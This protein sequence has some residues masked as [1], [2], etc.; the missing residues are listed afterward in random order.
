[1]RKEIDPKWYQIHEK[2]VSDTVFGRF[3]HP[4]GA[5]IPQKRHPEQNLMKNDQ[6]LGAPWAPKL[7]RKICIK[8]VMIFLPM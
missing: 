4:P 2:S 3:G 8:I 1:M 7:K 5:K 6:F